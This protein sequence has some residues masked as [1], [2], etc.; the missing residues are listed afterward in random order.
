MKKDPLVSVI[1]PHRNLRPQWLAEAKESL[2][3]QTFRDFELIEAVGED[4]S[5]FN[6]GAAKAKG[7]YLMFLSDDDRLTPTFL[8]ENVAWIERDGVG[9]SSP[10]LEN[11]GDVPEG[12]EGRH[13]PVR[14][15]L[16]TSLIRKSVW[17]SLGGYDPS[18]GPMM[19]VEFWWRCRKAGIRWSVCPG[20]FYYYRRH[21]SQDS[22]TADWKQAW[23]RLLAKHKD[24]SW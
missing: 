21:G 1:I 2:D 16:F 14:F 7:K 19:D 18:M 9:I 6:E 13:G 15:P 10:F 4:L 24:Y 20:S 22:A 12:Q 5:K 11:F 8:E 23:D 3:A 17:D